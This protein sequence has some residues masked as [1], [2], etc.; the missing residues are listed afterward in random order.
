MFT[1]EE[2][3][4]IKKRYDMALDRITNTNILNNKVFVFLIM[5]CEI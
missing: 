1:A 5:L 2:K 4:R 3:K